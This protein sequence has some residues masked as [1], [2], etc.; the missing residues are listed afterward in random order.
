MNI[1]LVPFTGLLLLTALLTPIQSAGASVAYTNSLKDSVSVLTDFTDYST[2]NSDY[3]DA[4]TGAW[5]LVD[6]NNG[7][8]LLS[9]AP[10]YM[11]GIGVYNRVLT[12][13]NDWTITVKTHLSQFTNSQTNP[14]YTVGISLVKTSADGMEYPNR[15]DLNLCRSG[16]NGASLKN[17]IVSSRYINNGQLD[18]A[19]NKDVP[20]AYLQFK[21]SAASKIVTTAY[22]TN[23]IRFFPIHSYYLAWIW[24]V[25]PKDAFTLALIA[26]DQPDGRVVPS[27]TVI[28]GQMF[29]HELTITSRSAPAY[30]NQGGGV[31]GA[32]LSIGNI[33]G[34]FNMY[35]GGLTLAGSS[36]VYTN[37]YTNI[38]GSWIFNTNVL[39]G[40]GVTNGGSNSLSGSNPIGGA[41]NGGV[42]PPGGPGGLP[43]GAGGGLV[44][45]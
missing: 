8:T 40:G 21:Y 33:G 44:L 26:N 7:L 25:R 12:A 36:Q 9:T 23:G 6:S 28:A 43:G 3:I 10:N 38:A 42:I 29:L 35:Y 17:F 1:R 13:S 18:I 30:S 11:D 24:G 2:I 27:Y 45:P 15:L 34:A 5:F 19:I 16:T 37:A 39:T 41:T 31:V 14:F 4:L 20:D 32:S 22:S